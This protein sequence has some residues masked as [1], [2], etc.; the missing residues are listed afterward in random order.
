MLPTLEFAPVI[1]LLGPHSVYELEPGCKLV[2]G[3][4][5]GATG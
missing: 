1:Q 2:A 3:R 4:K 5:E